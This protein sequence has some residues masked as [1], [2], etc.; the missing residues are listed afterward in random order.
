MTYS[1][2][3]FYFETSAVNYLVDRFNWA[4]AIA[5]KG[6]QSTKGNIWYLSSVTLWEILSTKNEERREDI[7]F[8]C[9]HL[10][11]EELLNSPSEFIINYINS[12]CPL[13]ENKYD[14]HSKLSLSKS[15]KN[16]CQDK[17]QTFIYNFESMKERM[18]HLQKLSKQLDKIIHRVVLDIT[19]SDDELSWQELVSFF[20]LR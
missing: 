16:I 11:H 8:Y 12:G 2:H 10:F 20:I 18:K 15:W 9:Q 17:R 7:I 19:V 1:N 13:V 3:N 14:F 5:T 4:D 6:H